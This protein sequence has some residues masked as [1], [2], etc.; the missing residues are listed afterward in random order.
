[1]KF[2]WSALLTLRKDAQSLLIEAA[3][4]EERAITDR[5]AARSAKE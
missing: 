5:L 4:G 1:L 3:P 2:E